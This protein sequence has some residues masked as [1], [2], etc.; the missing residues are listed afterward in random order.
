MWVDMI[1]PTFLLRLL[2]GRCYGNRFFGANWR[3][4]AYPPS[5]CALAFHNGWEDRN[6][7]AGVN[8]VS[9]PS[10]SDK[11]LVSLGPVTPEF[12]RRDCTG[13]ATQWALPRFS[14]LSVCPLAYLKNHK[15]NFTKFSV[16]DLWP[17]LDPSLAAV[18]CVMYFRFCGC[19][20]VSI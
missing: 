17:W 1:S 12:C 16:H 10:V 9:G 20:H 15:P 5:F 7:D 14:S 8:T 2:K 19:R 4:L 6:V 3:K 13:W 18:R 11:N